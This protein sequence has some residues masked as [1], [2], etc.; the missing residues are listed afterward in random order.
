MRGALLLLA[1]VLLAAAAGFGLC[2]AAGWRFD[3]A[4]VLPAAA[5][6]LLAGGAALVP[7]VLT[8]GAS[9]PSVAQAGLIGTVV[10]LFGCLV[11]AAV[12]LLVLK[13]GAAATYWVLAFYWATL[14]VL[15]VEFGRAVRSAPPAAPVAP[16][17]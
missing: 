1:A 3:A 15:V 5:S 12:L 6:A 17:Q 7:L 9:Q 2:A 10:H 16:K 8:R 11:G 14:V 4:R 13:Q